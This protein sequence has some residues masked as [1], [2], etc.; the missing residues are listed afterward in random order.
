MKPVNNE[1]EAISRDGIFAA[2]LNGLISYATGK[3][4]ALWRDLTA[5][6]LRIIMPD[7][8]TTN[9]GQHTAIFIFLVANI[10]QNVEIEAEVLNMLRP[11]K[12]LY[13][14][15]MEIDYSHFDLSNETVML[16]ITDILAKSAF[17]SGLKS[18]KA[19]FDEIDAIAIEYGVKNQTE[20]QISKT[21]R[22]AE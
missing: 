22:G 21:V 5:T 17:A 10:T 6:R 7:D 20:E 15:A 3:D 18:L 11:Y 8:I 9:Q 16:T 1:L 13:D 2:V 12:G 19:G 14:A 4:Y